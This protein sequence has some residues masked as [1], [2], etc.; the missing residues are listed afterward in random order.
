MLHQFNNNLNMKKILT[1]ISII[2]GT[3]IVINIIPVIVIAQTQTFTPPSGDQTFSPP[4]GGVP[5]LIT[6]PLNCGSAG[7]SDNKCDLTAFINLIL[8]NV[9]MPLAAVAAVGYIIWAGFSYVTAQGNPGKIAEAHKRL[10]Y[11]LIG[12]GILL[13]AAAISQVIQATVKSLTN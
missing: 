7:N 4:E 5:I 12:T 9:I 6:N 13:G 11:A 3:L 2:L 8:K 1:K 10:L